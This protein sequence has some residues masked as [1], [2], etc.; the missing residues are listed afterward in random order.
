MSSKASL[1]SRINLLSGLS[2]IE[3]PPCEAGESTAHYRWRCLRYCLKTITQKV[4]TVEASEIFISHGI[5][6]Q[7]R[8]LCH[9]E[10]SI[11][12]VGFNKNEKVFII[13]F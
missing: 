6:H 11:F 7:R 8:I 4:K 2:S 1:E 12:D 3:K 10:S 9:R 13:R 5:E